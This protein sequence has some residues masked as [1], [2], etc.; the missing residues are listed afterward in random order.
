MQYTFYTGKEMGGGGESLHFFTYLNL[1][2]ASV[3]LLLIFV[4]QNVPI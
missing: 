2:C 3:L 4:E 1:A